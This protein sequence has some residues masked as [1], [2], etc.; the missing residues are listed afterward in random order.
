MNKRSVFRKHLITNIYF[1]FLGNCLNH[2]VLGSLLLILW[3]FKESAKEWFNTCLVVIHGP[4]VSLSSELPIFSLCFEVIWIPTCALYHS[5]VLFK[6]LDILMHKCKAWS[7]T[8]FFLISGIWIKK[9]QCCYSKGKGK[10]CQVGKAFK[11][12]FLQ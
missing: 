5:E 3:W 10:I 4:T 9:G 11:R 6:Y 2:T 1:F 7:E 12:F 8:F